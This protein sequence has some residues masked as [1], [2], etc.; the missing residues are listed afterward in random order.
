MSRS[1]SRKS[2]FRS[3]E[4]GGECRVII[5][6]A[7]LPQDIA[8]SS[9][10]S[11]PTPVHPAQCVNNPNSHPLDFFPLWRH[12]M[13]VCLSDLCCVRV[14][15]CMRSRSM[16]VCAH[17]PKRGEPTRTET[18]GIGRFLLPRPDIAF[19][20][21]RRDGAPP[22]AKKGTGCHTKHTH[23]RCHIQAS[24]NCLGTLCPPGG[25]AN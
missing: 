14:C 4:R 17:F 12:S 20:L 9:V 6:V 3:T 11:F 13:C 24:N 2:F 1:E 25:G 16:F 7:T 23:T 8:S 22:P 21:R 10:W 5:G 19:H 18:A 15:V